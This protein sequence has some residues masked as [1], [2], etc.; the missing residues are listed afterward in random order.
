MINCMIFFYSTYFIIGIH[1]KATLRISPW[2]Q[3]MYLSR[4]DMWLGLSDSREHA[5]ARGLYRLWGSVQVVFL[6]SVYKQQYVSVLMSCQQYWLQGSC[7]YPADIHSSSFC[8][9]RNVS[10]PVI[11][12]QMNWSCNHCGSMLLS[13]KQT[14]K[15]T[16]T[17]AVFRH[18]RR[19]H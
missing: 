9:H 17:I 13:E 18:T 8:R 1:S 2:V 16:T 14:N 11:V 6:M 5:R 19:G 12:N 4:A 10:I 15:Q 7:Q 3:V